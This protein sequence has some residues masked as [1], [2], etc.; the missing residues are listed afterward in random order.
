MKNK[1]F[2]KNENSL[3]V[4]KIYNIFILLFIFI[5][6]SCYSERSKLHSIA[7]NNYL[8]KINKIHQD[9]SKHKKQRRKQ[10][11]TTFE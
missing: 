10:E 3:K 5:L 6:I 11:I 2:L 9:V 4:F 8:Q 1:N 7:R